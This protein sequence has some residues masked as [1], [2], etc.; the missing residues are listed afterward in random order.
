MSA[1]GHPGQPAGSRSSGESRR[2]PQS[3]D[4]G[5]VHQQIAELGI[6]SRPVTVT[7]RF[8]AGSPLKDLDKRSV[9]DGTEG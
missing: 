8:P 4:K 3:I 1:G 7:G 5:G 2:S 9:G 6:Q